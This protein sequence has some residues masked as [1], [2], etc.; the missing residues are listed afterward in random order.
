MNL[1]SKSKHST[2]SME[3]AKQVV[4]R[5]LGVVLVV[6]MGASVVNVLWQV[7]S[8]FV[9]GAPSSFTQELARFLLIWIGV[10]GAGYTVGTREHLAL[11]LIPEQLAGAARAWLRIVIQGFIA[12]F[13]VAVMIVGGLRLVYVQLTLGQTSA[14]LNIPIGLVYAVL[15]ITGAVMVFYVAVHIRGHLQALRTETFDQSAPSPSTDE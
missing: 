6:L 10:L 9:L 14:S 1:P 13:A 7:F 4:D 15:P 5:G 12:L 3:S 11:E 2:R 8:R